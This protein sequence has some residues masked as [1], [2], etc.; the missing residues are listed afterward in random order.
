MEL[1]FYLNEYTDDK[2]LNIVEKYI[3]KNL[4]DLDPETFIIETAKEI[5]SDVYSYGD[6]VFFDDDHTL[7]SRGEIR[8]F[9]NRYHTTDPC[10]SEYDDFDDWFQDSIYNLDYY[11]FSDGYEYAIQDAIERGLREWVESLK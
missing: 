7:C 11:R 3:R 4:L 9:W 1:Y 10:M 2:I 8:D 5:L 6:D